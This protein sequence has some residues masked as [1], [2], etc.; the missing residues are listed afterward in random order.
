MFALI[1]KLELVCRVRHQ[2][3]NLYSEVAK[4]WINYCKNQCY[5]VI[6]MRFFFT[7]FF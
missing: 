1:Y 5:T 2:T 6:H 7:F 4:P 3:E